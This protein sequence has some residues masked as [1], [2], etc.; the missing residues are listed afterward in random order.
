MLLCGENLGFLKEYFVVLFCVIT[1][2]HFFQEDFDR[3]VWL[4]QIDLEDFS[5]QDIELEISESSL[6][7]NDGSMNN[8]EQEVEEIE[9][10]YEPPSAVEALKC[11]TTFEL[12][13]NQVVLHREM[14]CFV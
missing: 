5:E 6:N 4:A 3:N 8:Q 7:N 11:L 13:Y 2:F 14:T 10:S 12:I 9:D 1:S